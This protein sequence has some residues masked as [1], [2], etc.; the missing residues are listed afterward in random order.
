[1]QELNGRNPLYIAQLMA[2][3]RSG[4]TMGDFN[5]A[6]GGG[7]PFN[8]SGTRPQDTEVTIDGAPAVRTRANGAII[9]D[10]TPTIPATYGVPQS[11][12][13]ATSSR[14]TTSTRFRS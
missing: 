1:M 6:V 11:T 14:S 12:M 9:G 3:M 10:L 2:G 4:S 5:F 8:V 13:S 7:V